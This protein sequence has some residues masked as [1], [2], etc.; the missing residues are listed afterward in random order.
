MNPST[1]GQRSASQLGEKGE[2]RNDYHAHG[3]M[4]GPY[5][6]GRVDPPKNGGPVRFVGGCYVLPLLKSKSFFQP[7]NTPSSGRP[8][9]RRGHG[10]HA[11]QLMKIKDRQCLLHRPELAREF[12]KKDHNRV[13]RLSVA[14][15]WPC[16]PLKQELS[17]VLLGT[18]GAP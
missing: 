15:G 12:R 8:G 6:F 5:I 17:S 10:A 3:T 1:R 14:S 9:I 18:R 7:P 11:H 16:K 4:E 2:V 13:A